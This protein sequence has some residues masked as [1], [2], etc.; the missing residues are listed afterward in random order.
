MSLT[1][2]GWSSIIGSVS[3]QIIYIDFNRLDNMLTGYQEAEL[4]APVETGKIRFEFKKR[5]HL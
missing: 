4:C 5:A 3:Q 1:L 2:Q